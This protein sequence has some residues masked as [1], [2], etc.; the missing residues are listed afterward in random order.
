[1][2]YGLEERERKLTA[3]HESTDKAERDAKREADYL[4]TRAHEHVKRVKAARAL[5]AEL[6]DFTDACVV[7]EQAAN[8]VDILIQGALDLSFQTWIRSSRQGPDDYQDDAKTAI[9]A[10][11]KA[12]PEG[13]Q[14]PF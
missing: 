3:M 2:E 11:R 14:P 1:L 5:I 4:A 6:D 10:E 13:V 7:K 12:A 8:I 9:E